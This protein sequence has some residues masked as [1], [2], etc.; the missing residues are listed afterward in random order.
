MRTIGIDAKI[1]RM[2]IS[3]VKAAMFQ[4]PRPRSLLRRQPLSL[5]RAA[6]SCVPR[7]G[8]LG[9]GDTTTALPSEFGTR[10]AGV[11]PSSHADATDNSRE[12]LEAWRAASTVGPALAPVVA[13]AVA[14]DDV[15]ERTVVWATDPAQ[16]DVAPIALP[17]DDALLQSAPPFVGELVRNWQDRKHPC[18]F[19]GYE[20][21]SSLVVDFKLQQVRA[22]ATAWERLLARGE[23]PRLGDGSFPLDAPSYLSKEHPLASLIW[24]V[25][26]ASGSLPLLGAPTEWRSARLISRD[27][28]PLPR[29]SRAPAHL[30]LATLAAQ[31]E[32][33]PEQLRL[34]TRVDE[35]DLRAFLQAALFLRL[36][37]W[38][39]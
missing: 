5:W 35:R 29:L 9:S 16:P 25:G 14:H 27:W 13:P 6:V 12:E 24:A 19:A 32:V 33:T 20:D 18:L 26:L 3:A 10:F 31:T 38:A 7:V 39:R 8:R 17:P 22:D 2:S 1:D 36:L 34:A 30:H 11:S 23:L 15:P 21:G 28:R 4:R 37:E